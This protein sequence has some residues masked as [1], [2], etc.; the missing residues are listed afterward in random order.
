TQPGAGDL[1]QQY[2]LTTTD[3]LTRVRMLI[4]SSPLVTLRLASRELPPFR[5]NV[6]STVFPDSA[7]SRAL[8]YIFLLRP[9]TTAFEIAAGNPLPYTLTATDGAPSPGC[10]AQVIAQSS[11]VIR[12]DGEI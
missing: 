3:T 11:G 2:T 1:Y 10:E 5:W 7:S 9:G 8:R 4:E 12:V 6:P